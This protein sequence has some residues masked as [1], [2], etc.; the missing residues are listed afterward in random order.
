MSLTLRELGINEET[1]FGYSGASSHQSAKLEK[2]LMHLVINTPASQSHLGKKFCDYS[3][4][5][6]N[7]TNNFLDQIFKGLKVQ[8]AVYLFTSYTEKTKFKNDLHPVVLARKAE[9]ICLRCDN[10]TKVSLYMA[11]RNAIA[12]GNILEHNGFYILYSVSDS[13]NE[14]DSNLTFFLRIRKLENIKTF[15]T[16]LE[17]YQ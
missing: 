5:N 4:L 16:V 17:Q 13:R 11:V 2:L 15:L 3:K 1:A 12:H 8:N 14:F 7:T 9:L 10:G 6:S